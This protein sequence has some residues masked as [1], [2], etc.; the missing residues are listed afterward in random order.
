[1]NYKYDK[2]YESVVDMMINM[3]TICVFNYVF[4]IQYTTKRLSVTFDL[5]KR[6][7]G[8]CCDN[9][10]KIYGRGFFSKGF[11]AY[12]DNLVKLRGATHE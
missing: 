5:F 2:R 3:I 9:N 6:N 7:E 8:E 12:L 4:V 1:M 10:N 11:D